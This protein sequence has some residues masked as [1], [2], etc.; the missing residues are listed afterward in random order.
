MVVRFWHPTS[1]TMFPSLR[2][3]HQALK[4]SPVL[5]EWFCAKCGQTSDHFELED[6]QEEFAQ[7][8]CEPPSTEFSHFQNDS[9]KKR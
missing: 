4:W 1:S 3:K 8:D 9:W 2:R 5:E 7:Y 6:A